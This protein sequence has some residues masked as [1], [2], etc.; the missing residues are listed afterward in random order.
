MA[1]QGLS[2]RSLAPKV[3][4]LFDETVLMLFDETVDIGQGGAQVPK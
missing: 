3:L 1:S 2:R 4:M